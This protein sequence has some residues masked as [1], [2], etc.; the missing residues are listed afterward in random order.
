MVSP[1]F[2]LL[3]LPLAYA[4]A[5]DAKFETGVPKDSDLHFVIDP[6]FKVQKAEL[7]GTALEVC[8]DKKTSNCYKDNE[9]SHINVTATIEATALLLKLTDADQPTQTIQATFAP[10]SSAI[11]MPRSTAVILANLAILAYFY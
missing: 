10:I 8:T 5:T 4:L 11:W 1:K 6:G 3:L 9:F 7:N 2:F